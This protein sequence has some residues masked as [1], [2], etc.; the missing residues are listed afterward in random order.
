[1]AGSAKLSRQEQLEE[2]IRVRGTT[3]ASTKQKEETKAR[4]SRFAN[5][6]SNP[7]FQTIFDEALS[8]E[9][10]QA[11]VTK[12]LT[13]A[14]T[15]EENRERVKAFDVFKEYLQAEREVMATQIIK[16]SDTRNFATLKTTFEDINNALIDFEGDMK[17]L[18]DILDALHVLRADNQTL[19]AFREIKDEEKRREAIAQRDAELT[20]QI[21]RVQE[22][23][24]ELK[25]QNRIEEQNKGFFGFGGIKPESIEKI[26]RNKVAMEN[27]AAELQ[28]ISEEA[29]ANAEQ[30]TAQNS[31]SKITNLEA[32]EKLK[33]MLNLA[34]DEHQQRSKRLI[35]SAVNFV[36]T[37]KDK[38]ETIRDH[39]SHMGDQ[40]QN[41]E[42]ANGQMSFIYALL[43]E[44]VKGAEQENKRIREEVGK[45]APEENM[46]QKL[47]REGK[48]RD[49]DEHITMLETSA[50]DTVATVADLT[51][52]SIRIKNMNDANKQQIQMARDM[53]AR[54]VAGVADRL[55]TVIQAVGAA[56]I[57]E[58][59]AMTA[60]TLKAMSDNTDV[61]AQKESMRIAMGIQDRNEQMV[62]AIEGLAQ[63]GEVNRVATEFT[64]QGI[65]TLREN[66]EVMEKTAREVAETVLDSKAV[67]AD[68]VM[69]EGKK[70]EEKTEK[71]T[72]RSPFGLGA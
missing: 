5:I 24:D 62:R 49:L 28:R 64:R 58:S 72:A 14:G 27:A 33:E 1:M 66:L 19:D 43:G 4:D 37:S 35:D 46:V 6:E 70:A 53:H 67:V 56:A 23:I 25:T 34:T 63:Y 16:M 39:L 40:I 7:F 55:S 59:N 48:Q 41:L 21:K 2:I 52:A 32:K 10:K 8:P 13:F 20:D 18:T 12:L 50:A 65:A 54:G 22:R 11:A 42:D 57:A 15:R 60:E 30:A 47:Q 45:A 9:Q 29:K 26:A 61:I 44:G 69:G 3:A 51:S 68:I 17:P 36:Q 38:I 71:K 31:E